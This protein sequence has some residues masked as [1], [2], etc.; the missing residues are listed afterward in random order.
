MWLLGAAGVFFG[1]TTS[2]MFAMSGTL[3]GPRAAGRWAGAQNVVGQVAGV[4]APIV[5]GVIVDRT[6]AFTWA[7]ACSAA[8]SVLAMVAWGIP[9]SAGGGGA[10][11]S[12]VRISSA[13]A[14]CRSEPA[15][16]LSGRATS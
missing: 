5:T 7:F 8:A 12:T 3:A 2:T 14:S 10:V 13:R 9:D 6:G 1:L 16:R 4:I 15:L 11:A